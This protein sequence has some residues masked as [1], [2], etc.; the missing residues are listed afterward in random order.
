MPKTIPSAKCAECRH[1]RFDLVTKKHNEIADD[2]CTYACDAFPNGIP[3][4]IL[5]GRMNH[6]AP[7]PGDHGIRFESMT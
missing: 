4:K 7:Y 2:N 3:Q 1:L 6:H 5:E